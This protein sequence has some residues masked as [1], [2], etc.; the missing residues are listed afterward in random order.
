LP[1]A[2]PVTRGRWVPWQASLSTFA[3][4]VRDINSVMYTSFSFH[5]THATRAPYFGVDCSSFVS[6]ALDF[7]VRSHTGTI[8][9]RAHRVATQNIFALQVGDIFNS[10]SHSLLV[11]AVEHDAAGNLVAVETR[12]QTIPFPRWNRYGAG[13]NSGGLDAL[14]RRTF[15]RGFALYRSNT[16][17]NVRFIPDPA[18]DVG[19]GPRHTVTASADFGGHI[20]PTGPIPV[21]EGEN[22][23]LN[24]YPSRG[25]GIARVLVNGVD[26]GPL[27]RF[28]FY[29]VTEDHYIEV[30]FALT[31]SPFDDVG[32]ADWFFPEIMYVFREDLMRGTSYTH[33]SPYSTTNRAMFI[34][35][36]ARMAGVE[37]R[38]F[39]HTGTVAGSSV[40]VRSGPGTGYAS[41]GLLPR[42]RAVQ[43]VGSSADWY[44]IVHGGW[45][46]YMRNDLVVSQY[47]TFSDVTPGS[48][49][50]P[51]AEWAYSQGIVGNPAGRFYPGQVLPRQEMAT[52]LYRHAV[53]AGIQLDNNNAPPF[54]DLDSADDWAR[55][56][57]TAMQRAGII[58]GVGD[59]R[60]DPFSRTNR[61]QVA[62][63][64][65]RFHERYGHL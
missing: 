29:D 57:I 35:I 48:F 37:A 33:F 18:V 59:N 21:I 20:N 46:G 6:W 53:A 64:I 45:Y 15:D 8:P 23:T 9:L 63:V 10:P 40:H 58:G 61:A 34:T 11:T 51:Y 2:Q 12:D 55:A 16:I 28:T 14:V 47:G 42:D 38:D 32:Q 1:Y 13:G 25:F 39:A 41:L 60:F 31:G 24:I 3:D 36:L 49:Y 22:L 4:A 30:E 50:A 54:S 26:V 62:A 65:A 5:G 19:L 56:G 44:R 7:S 52:F 27:P 43:I 17:D